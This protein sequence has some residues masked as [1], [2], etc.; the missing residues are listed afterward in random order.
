[1]QLPRSDGIQFLIHP[2]M[3][4]TVIQ[5]RGHLGE[6]GWTCRDHTKGIACM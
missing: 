6:F 4:T 5:L 3:P 2:C 1:M